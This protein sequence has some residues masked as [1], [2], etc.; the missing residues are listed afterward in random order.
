VVACTKITVLNA[1]P[2]SF[3]VKR[4]YLAKF[5]KVIYVVYNFLFVFA[6]FPDFSKIIMTH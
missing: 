3:F 6:V 5:Q 4:D 2:P 1:E